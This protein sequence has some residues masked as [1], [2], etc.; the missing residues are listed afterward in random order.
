MLP[1]SAASDGSP[2]GDQ[3]E[4]VAAEPLTVVR[5]TDMRELIFDRSHTHA[6]TFPFA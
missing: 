3:I 6:I 5:G 2:S 1:A 4:S